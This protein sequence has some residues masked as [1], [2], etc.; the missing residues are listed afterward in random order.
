MKEALGSSETS[1]LTRATQR[2]F[3]EDTFFSANVVSSSMIIVTLLME[4]LRSSVTG[5]YKSHTA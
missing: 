1:I 2:N 4:M 3:P 5:S